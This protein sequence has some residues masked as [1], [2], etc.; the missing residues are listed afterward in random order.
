[1]FARRDRKKW[2]QV[3]LVHGTNG[4]LRPLHFLRAFATFGARGF[5]AGRNRQAGSQPPVLAC[6]FLAFFQIG[7]ALA[8]LMSVAGL[9][10]RSHAAFVKP[11]IFTDL[12]HETAGSFTP[13]SSRASVSPK[14]VS[15]GRALA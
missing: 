11:F 8:A 9:Y 12:C 1:M 15:L 10:M 13:F 2:S 5:R 14:K 3:S 7:E 6:P 4:D